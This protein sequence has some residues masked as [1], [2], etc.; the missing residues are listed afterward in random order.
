M[1]VTFVQR[2]E[3]LPHRISLTCGAALLARQLHSTGEVRKPRHL[4]PR[5]LTD[6]TLPADCRLMPSGNS[7][8]P[9]PPS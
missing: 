9:S 7:L 5:S 8:I 4:N 6:R 2:G 3:V 1:S